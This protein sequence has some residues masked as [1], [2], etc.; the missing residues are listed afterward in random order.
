LGKEG[1]MGGTLI[2]EKDTECWATHRSV[3]HWEKET[4]TFVGVPRKNQTGVRRGEKS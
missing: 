3:E 4:K 2:K 1:D